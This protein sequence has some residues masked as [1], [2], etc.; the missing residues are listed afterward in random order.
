M[1]LQVTNSPFN[2]S[3]VELLNRLLPTLTGNQVNW[4]G[5][6][7]SALALQ[8]NEST[9]T[10]PQPAAP[11]SQLQPEAV[12]PPVSREVTVLFGSQTGNC[13][14]LAASLARKLE[15]QGF[16][17]TVSAMNN[18]KPNALKKV[19]NLLLLVSTHGEGEP[20]DNARAF[21]EFLYSKRA[22][23]L[24]SLQFSV[25]GLGDTSYEFFCQTGKDFDKR[26][27]EL[28]G[29]RLSPRVDCD[30]D[31]D[32]PV[33]EW[34]Q[35]VISSLNG[36]L[37]APAV[38]AAAVQAAEQADSPQS[39]YS[40]NHPFMAE[41]LENLNLNGRGSD[42]E[43]RHLE[44]SLAG[45]NLTFE[46]G[47]SLGVYPENHPQLVADIIAAMGWN[48]EETV[49]LNK[50]GEEGT[51]QEA[52]LR[53]YEITVLTKP[54]I[55]QAAKL[56]SSA[57]L[58]GLLLPE[59]QQELKD[60]IQG[61]D[62]LDLIRDFAPWEVPAG[63]FV[64]ILRKLPARLYS[65]SS[66]CRAN[67][68]EVHFTV[69]A[70]RYQSHGRERYGVCSVHCA[71]RVQPGDTLP[72][73]I[74]NNPNFKLPVNPDVPV[75]MIG[76]GTGVAPFRS[77]LEER[78]EQGAE[79]KTWLFYGDRHFVTDF[80]YQTDWQRMLKDG[81]LTKLDV[82]FSRDTEE[83]VYVQHRILEK[84]RE[85]YAWLQEGAHVYVCGDEK[86]MAHDVH[87]ALITV[88]QE[89]GGMSPEA[90]AAYLDQLQQEQRYQRDVY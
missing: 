32:E 29:Q 79:G 86:H 80:L 90:A 76:P 38:A 58:Q 40:R 49:P 18:F 21:Y 15:E 24:E 85:L 78:E 4:L 69:R 12:S 62:L 14:R 82:A 31:Y 26:L 30:L 42:R 23:Q 87:S 5:G 55:E 9:A 65:I 17:V 22:P 45:S 20:P 19:E 61:R 57:V 56:S 66:S 44:L 67:P 88:I 83:K 89:E 46:P 60:Y 51:L 72:I 6:Y 36:R 27:E 34:F 59:R 75:I 53:H 1:Q 41:V 81:V 25:L 8:G 64:S 63:S 84:S 71:E 68:E 11:A 47:D 13:Q 7:L 52:L 37:N 2:E 39:E 74:Q 54:L 35:Q 48:P 70:V 28:G 16:Q 77:F 73:Y 43:T 10:A 3:Q 50:K 33:A